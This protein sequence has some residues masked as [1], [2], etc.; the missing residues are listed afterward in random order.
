MK[1]IFLLAQD[2]ERVVNGV[3]LGAAQTDGRP[4][5]VFYIYI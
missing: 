5:N 3:K 1:I 2:R 4:N